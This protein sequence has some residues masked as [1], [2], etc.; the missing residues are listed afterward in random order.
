M[1]CIILLAG[2]PLL[3]APSPHIY[4]GGRE[5][6][7]TPSPAVIDG[8]VY[9][10]VS[11]H[12]EGLSVLV[13]TED[14]KV[15]LRGMG[16]AEAR[17][18]FVMHQGMIYYPIVPA[19]TG[20]RLGAR[21]VEKTQK[22]YI[23]P[24]IDSI[25]PEVFDRMLTLR[26]TA[27]YPVTPKVS[28]V[29]D[30]WRLLIEVPNAQLFTES[31]TIP[32]GQG[33]IT[34]IRAAQYSY[35]PPM[36][37]I[38]VDVE[39]RP[40]YRVLSGLETTQIRLRMGVPEA[41]TPEACTLLDQLLGS[42]DSEGAAWEVVGV[43]VEPVDEKSTRIVVRTTAPVDGSVH[44]LSS[45][46]RLALD[47]PNTTLRAPQ[48]DVPPETPLV[49]GVRLGQF[50]ERIS[51]VVVDL[52]EEVE[53]TLSKGAD[54]GT[55]VL[56]L[57]SA[58]GLEPV[59]GIQGLKV[60]L[61]PGHGGS[62]HGTTGLSGRREQDINLDVALRLYKMLEQAKARPMMTRFGDDTVSLHARPAMANAKGAHIFISIHA[63]SNGRPNSAR[64]IE[65]YYG[66]DRSYRLA[67]TLHQQ[68]VKELGA[69]DRRV[70]K[71]PGLV[72]TRETKM[73]SVL[74]EIGYMNHRE[75]DRL[76]GLPE[77]RQRVAKAIFNGIVKYMGGEAA[78]DSRNAGSPQAE[79]S[80]VGAI[81]LTVSLAGE[82][83]H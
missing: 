53:Y 68:L 15:V 64:G 38:V 79:E 7:C 5:V 30:P 13:R 9:V 62:L 47:I 69:P 70:R 16:E 10:P 40:Q 37:R 75:E 3:A 41:P 48:P 51:R 24:R 19:C 55:L 57:R 31:T 18:P 43:Q 77:Y 36:V 59:R 65:T 26:I 23:A 25:R 80:E 39:G 29:S 33:E 45:P 78:L 54:P 20:I 81:E 56:I 28:V 76:L 11:F 6:P 63:N 71:R 12:Y 14:G 34:R 46:P 2:G 49:Q 82:E 67:R 35:E 42:P 83:Q 17:V 72:V 22:L 58:L 21:W 27:G 4:I 73:P 61:D 44:P 66:H 50:T 74:L 8:Q 32:I 52:A 1:L 60:M